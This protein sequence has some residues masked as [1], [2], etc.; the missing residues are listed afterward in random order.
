M[1]HARWYSWKRVAAH[2]IAWI[3]LGVLCPHLFDT[4]RVSARSVDCDAKVAITIFVDEQSMESVLGSVQQFED[5]FNR[6]CRHDLVF[7]SSSPLSEASKQ[8]AA[9]RTTGTCIF[10]TVSSDLWKVDRW[11]RIEA[12][13]TG[14]LANEFVLVNDCSTTQSD[15]S[16]PCWSSVSLKKL[17][18]LQ[19]YD[20]CWKIQLDVSKYVLY[21]IESLVSNLVNRKPTVSKAC[22]SKR[23]KCTKVTIQDATTKFIRHRI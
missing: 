11:A 18:R 22:V 1:I 20:W 3:V 14:G 2:A 19:Q 4:P 17:K 23:S 9:N 12:E 10:E 5:T 7:F 13:S 21:S 15:R 8:L 6:H 16:L